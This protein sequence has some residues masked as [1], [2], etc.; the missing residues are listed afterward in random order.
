MVTQEFTMRKTS[1]NLN[2]FY[3]FTQLLVFD[4][5]M[6]VYNMKWGIRAQLSF[7]KE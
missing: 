3:A 2:M 5:M 7:V 4:A 6:A 1:L